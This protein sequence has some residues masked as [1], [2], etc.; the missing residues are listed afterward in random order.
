MQSANTV[1]NV[2]VKLTTAVFHECVTKYIRSH[3]NQLFYLLYCLHPCSLNH[4]FTQSKWR[5]ANSQ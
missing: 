3:R 5:G 4:K 2:P 1:S